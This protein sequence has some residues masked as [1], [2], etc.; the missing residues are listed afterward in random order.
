MTG[1]GAEAGSG[2]FAGSAATAGDV[3]ATAAPH[4]VQKRVLGDSLLPQVVQKLVGK[5]AAAGAAAAVGLPHA[6]QNFEEPLT[7]LP[8]D[9]QTAMASSC[10]VLSFQGYSDRPGRHE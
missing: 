10:P 2:A 3:A 4:P 8:H 1:V 5:A 6:V 7:S 9:E